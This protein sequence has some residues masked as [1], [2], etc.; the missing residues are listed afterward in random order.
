[1][2]ASQ[3]TAA[4]SLPDDVAS[5]HEMLQGLAQT[6]QERDRRI[7]QLEAAMDALIRQRYAPKRERYV[8]PDQQL[9]FGEPGEVAEPPESPDEDLQRRVDGQEEERWRKG[10][11]AAG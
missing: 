9:L 7:A 5:C 3:D 2:S 6:L 4:L 11:S 1:M 10:T 8:D